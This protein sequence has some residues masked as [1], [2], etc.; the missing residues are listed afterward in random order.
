MRKSIDYKEELK[1]LNHSMLSKM[2]EYFES[3]SELQ[4]SKY[5]AIFNEIAKITRNY[6]WVIGKLRYSVAVRPFEV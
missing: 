1:K 5:E 3:G 6:Y 2:L 4:H